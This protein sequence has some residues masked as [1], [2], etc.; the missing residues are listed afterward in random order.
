MCE[1]KATLIKQ[2]IVLER[3]QVE[4]WVSSRVLSRVNENKYSHVERSI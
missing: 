1:R 3:E 2:D 4:R